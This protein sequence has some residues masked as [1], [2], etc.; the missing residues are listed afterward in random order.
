MADFIVKA[1]LSAVALMAFIAIPI[2]NT[3]TTC[4][5]VALLFGGAAL[6][7]HTR[8]RKDNE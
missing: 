3:P 4:L 2:G 7:L 5:I 6:L 8:E 1:I